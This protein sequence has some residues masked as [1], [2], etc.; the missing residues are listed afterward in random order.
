M[1]RTPT[2]SDTTLRISALILAVL[3]V[4]VGLKLAQ[5]IFAPLLMAVVTG[6]IFAP[7]VDRGERLGLPRPAVVLILM[8]LLFFVAGAIAFMAEPYFWT[9]VDQIPTVKYEIRRLL[10][11]Y[12]DLIRGLDE[13]NR[14]MGQ[15]LGSDGGDSPVADMPGLTD[16]LLLA[17]ILLAQFL[18]FLGGMFF[19]MLT[20]NGI[21]DWMS[22][23]IGSRVDTGVIK[24][25]F[26]AAEHAVSRYFAMISIINLGLGVCVGMPGAIVWGIAAALLNFVLYLGPAAMA[27]ALLL[28]GMLNYDGLLSFAPPAIYLALNMIEAQFVTPGLVGKHIA[29]NPFLIFVSLVFW[30]WLW[31]PAGGILAI[32]ITV[33][34]IKLFD[35][36]DERP[37]ARSNVRAA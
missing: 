28:S 35:I 8:V 19:F 16:A 4:L 37:T 14:E 6:V 27:I 20:R 25:R 33:M 5:D 21:Y 12:R 1:S 15:A 13:V 24:E 30:L 11:E 18:I 22:R 3:A 17:P 10:F 34:L 29:V 31:G 7:L 9:A 32:P 26:C 2:T 23:H 36:F